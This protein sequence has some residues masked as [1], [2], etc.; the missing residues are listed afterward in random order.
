MAILTDGRT[1]ASV[2]LSKSPAGARTSSTLIADTGAELSM[3]PDHAHSS[4]LATT[5]L[6]PTINFQVAGSSISAVFANSLTVDTDV[7]VHGG[8][9]VQWASG[10]QRVAVHY[11]AVGQAPFVQFEGILGMD[12]LDLLD[13]DPVKDLAQTRSYLARRA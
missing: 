3:L 5:T 6:G 8:G 9:S 11:L 1:T 4:T 13:A 10:S 7:E 2:S 12:L